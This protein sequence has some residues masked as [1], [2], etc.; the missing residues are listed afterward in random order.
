MLDSDASA[1][2]QCDP[3]PHRPRQVAALAQYLAQVPEQSLALAHAPALLLEAWRSP[4]TLR[5]PRRAIDWN[6]LTAWV[7]A[8]L[9]EPLNV[10]DLARHVHLSPAQFAARC[11][12][13]LGMT[14]LT[15]LQRQRLSQARTLRDAGLPVQ[16]IARRTG[17]RSPSALTAA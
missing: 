9:D 4:A 11:Q 5:R 8:R 15:W 3:Q 10:A 2:A 12:D 6:A 1:W 16:E 7:H 13:A 17:Y 14:P